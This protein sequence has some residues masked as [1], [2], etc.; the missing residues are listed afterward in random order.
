M[1]DI[2]VEALSW[3][4]TPYMDQQCVKGAGVDCAMLL[5]GVAKACE[6]LP[7]GWKVPVYSPE[8][9]IHQNEEVFLATVHHLGCIPISHRPLSLGSILL[10][11]Y[12][13]VSS[14]A[15]IVV[16]VEPEPYIVH[17]SRSERYVTHHRLDNKLLGRLRQTF[18]FP[19]RM[20]A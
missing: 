8:W 11:Q 13:R 7:Q 12:G 5:V 9:H 15:A 2:V 4:K 20:D 1:Q 19:N 6:R 10:F 17:A 18:S 14:H 3:V 16:T